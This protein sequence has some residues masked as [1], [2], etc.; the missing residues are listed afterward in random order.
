MKSSEICKR[1]KAIREIRSINQAEIA[2][3]L[4]LT[5]SSYAKIEKG[6]SKLSMERFLQIVEFLDTDP[7]FYFQEIYNPK[8][9]PSR[10]YKKGE[11]HKPTLEESLGYTL[12]V[13]SKPD[14]ALVDNLN[15]TKPKSA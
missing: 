11:P 7:A 3:H 4:G 9:K 8:Q 14:E 2:K 10:P 15:D 1:I 12:Y 13:V 6:I 5:Q